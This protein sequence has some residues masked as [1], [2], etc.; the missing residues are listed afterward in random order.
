VEDQ[1]SMSNTDI[2][3]S[4]VR[5]SQTGC[6][7]RFDVKIWLCCCSRLIRR[8]RAKHKLYLSRS[9]LKYITSRNTRSNDRLPSSAMRRPTYLAEEDEKHTSKGHKARTQGQ[10][11]SHEALKA[12]VASKPPSNTNQHVMKSFREAY[13][14]QRYTGGAIIVIRY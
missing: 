14:S 1:L 10:L 5:S 11:T 2:R 13:N 8:G 12:I 9:Y 3:R 7:I 6:E 4:G